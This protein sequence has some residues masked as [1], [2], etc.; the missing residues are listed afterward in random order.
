MAFYIEKG[1][2]AGHGSPPSI[3]T[4]ALGSSE[5]NIA[6]LSSFGY[7]CN[8]DVTSLRDIDRGTLTGSLSLF[9]IKG[10]FILLLIF[11]IILFLYF[12]FF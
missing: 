5:P 3:N 12:F 1:E 6:I 2:G 8:C 11:Y 9:N 10:H 7:G 4:L